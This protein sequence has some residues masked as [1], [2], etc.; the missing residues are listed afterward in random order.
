[1]YIAKKDLQKTT[2]PLQG[3][4]EGVGVQFQIMKDTL[5]VVQPVK[6]GPAESVGIQIGDKIIT[7]DDSVAV[8]K[9]CTNDWVFKKLRG[10]KGK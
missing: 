6:G 5:V 2:E 10:K 3:N 4:F 9:I 8:G 7:I 1:M